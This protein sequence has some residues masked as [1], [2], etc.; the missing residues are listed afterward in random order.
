MCQVLQGQQRK[1][2]GNSMSIF[3]MHESLK[4]LLYK[5]ELRVTI[6]PQINAFPQISSKFKISA[7]PPPVLWKS[8]KTAKNYTC[9]FGRV[10]SFIQLSAYKS[11]AKAHIIKN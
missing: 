10:Q 8:D 11:K 7:C 1:E 2:L 4:P 6:N 5:L 3:Y 9:R